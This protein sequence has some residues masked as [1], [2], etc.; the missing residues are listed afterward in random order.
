MLILLI[1]FAI[2]FFIE[3]L[4]TNYLKN[5]LIAGM[6]F[7]INGGNL[8]LSLIVISKWILGTIIIIKIKSHLN[9]FKLYFDY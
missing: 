8:L 2:L 4:W 7:Q 1:I 6:K 9:G 5:D 3:K